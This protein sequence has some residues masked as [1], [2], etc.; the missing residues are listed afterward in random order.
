MIKTWRIVVQ[1]N[2]HSGYEI[3]IVVKASTQK[4]AESF[5]IN[6]IY[7]QGYFHVKLTSCEEIMNSECVALIPIPS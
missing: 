4:M 1:V 6:N 3:N 7:K 2:K 5:A